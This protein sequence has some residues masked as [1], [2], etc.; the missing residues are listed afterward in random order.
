LHIEC[1]RSRCDAKYSG[2]TQ[3]IINLIWL[4]IEYHT[5]RLL[6]R[7]YHPDS[8]RFIERDRTLCNPS[9]FWRRFQTH[10]VRALS[11]F[12]SIKKLDVCIIVSQVSDIC[13]EYL[14]LNIYWI[15]FAEYA[16]GASS[17][18][19]SIGDGWIFIK[20]LAPCIFGFNFVIENVITVPLSRDH[21]GCDKRGNPNTKDNSI[22]F[23]L[24]CQLSQC[25]PASS[26]CG[27]FIR[28]PASTRPVTLS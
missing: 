9:A 25:V 1:I 10:H 23:R 22:E 28:T 18:F 3:N 11:N 16:G 27:C 4:Q 24:T 19:S 13:I 8:F 7:Q 21:Y 17:N 14:Y 12:F 2:L 26:L 20:E 6:R 5:L 15:R